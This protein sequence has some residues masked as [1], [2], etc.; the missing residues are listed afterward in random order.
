MKEKEVSSILKEHG[1][2]CDVDDAGDYYCIMDFGECQ[3]Q[4]IPSIGRRSDHF[5]ISLMPSVSS[6]LFSKH[7]GFILGE[8][9]DHVPIS[10][11]NEVPKK[12]VDPTTADVLSAADEAVSWALDQKIENGLTAYRE[13]ATDA[14][15]A[16][17]LRHL[18]ALAM[19]GD[20]DR[21]KFYRDSFSQGN[22]LGFV[23]YVTSEMIDRAL[24][25]AEEMKG[26]GGN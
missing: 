22:R 3:L 8:S 6:R 19:A 14:K 17:P 21:L 16:M 11:A 5:R 1:W 10:T 9:R 26:N 20:V 15:G 4:V 7:V 23:P 24:L 12:I 25:I 2:R 13:M 18:A